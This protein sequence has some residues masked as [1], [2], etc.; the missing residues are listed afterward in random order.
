MQNK[1]SQK[2]K[3]KSLERTTNL[4]FLNSPFRYPGNQI[5][6][7]D[8]LLLLVPEHHIFV[9]PFCGGAS[10]FFAKKKVKENWLNDIDKELI[11]TYIIIRDQPE[12]FIAFLKKEE[13]SQERH[14]YFKT[15]FMPQGRFDIAARWFYLNRTSCLETMSKFWRYD[16]KTLLKPRGWDKILYI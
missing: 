5:Y 16:N 2:M 1:N 6:A 11:E 4:D 3:T 8:I 10:E 13:S 7:L 12:E 9:E 14:D 15:E